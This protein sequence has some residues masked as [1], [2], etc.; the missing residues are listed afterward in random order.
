MKSE[1]SKRA[2]KLSMKVFSD[3]RRGAEKKQVGLLWHYGHFIKDFLMPLNDWLIDAGIN[4]EGVTLFMEDVP[5]QTVGEFASTVERFTGVRLVTLPSPAYH[6]LPYNTLTLKGYGFGPF[7]P[8]TF[9]KVIE[10]V[11]KRFPVTEQGGQVVLIQRGVAK[12]G[13]ERSK[14]LDKDAK[15]SGAQRR[16]IHNHEEVASFLQRRYG[17]HFTNVTLEGMTFEEQV[18]VFYNAR[19]IIGQHGAGLNNLI[20]MRSNDA[21]VIEL[22]PHDKVHPFR[23]MSKCKGLRYRTVG[24]EVNWEALQSAGKSHIDLDLKELTAKL[25]DLEKKDSS[26]KALSIT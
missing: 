18:Q 2:P 14:V 6:A 16:T 22:Y 20:W 25:E 4:P 17:D 11:E 26:L 7:V 9:D 21:N 10:S 24:G 5:F 3:R 1:A 12:H 19:L 23:V 13:F 15:S 8:E